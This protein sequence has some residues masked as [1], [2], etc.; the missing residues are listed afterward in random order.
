VLNFLKRNFH[1]YINRDDRDMSIE[2]FN[3]RHAYFNKV[4]CF[5]G[6]EQLPSEYEMILKRLFSMYCR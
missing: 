1:N 6:N 4:N 2:E 3:D 5:G